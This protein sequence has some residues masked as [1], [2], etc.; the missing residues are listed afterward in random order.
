MYFKIDNGSW[1]SYN[2]T[3]V[4]LNKYNNNP[5]GNIIFQRYITN[6]YNSCTEYLKQIEDGMLPQDARGAL[7]IDLATEVAYTYNIEEW[8]NIIDLRYYGIT[9]TPHP[10]A[11]IIASMIRDELIKIGY[12]FR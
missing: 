8:R 5:K 6:T 2:N 9:G 3:L 4:I 10:N 12:N 11:K 1:H 7:P